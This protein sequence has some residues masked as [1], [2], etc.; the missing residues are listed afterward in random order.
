ME[1]GTYKPNLFFGIK[2]RDPN[3]I[4]IGLVWIL[5]DT[6][7]RNLGVRHTYKYESGEGVIAY[8]D[9]HDGWGGSK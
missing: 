2:N 7:Y 8:Y 6:R 1:W 5:P 3:P 4:T 9:F